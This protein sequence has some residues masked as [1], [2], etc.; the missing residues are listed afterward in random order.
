[1]KDFELV[2]F[3][4]LVLP[5]DVLPQAVGEQIWRQYSDKILVEFPSVKTNHC[6]RLVAQGWV[7][8]IPLTA[9]FALHIRPKVNLQNLFRMWEYAYNLRDLHFLSGLTGVGTLEEFYE[10]LAAVLAQQV[11]DRARKGIHRH[12]VPQ[13]AVLPY[14]RGKMK[15]DWKRPFAVN[16]ATEYH[17]H[18]ADIPDNQLLAYTLHHIAHSHR[19]RPEVQSV[20]RRAYHAVMGAT[21][22]QPMTAADCIGRFYT[23]L[24]QDYQPLHALCRFFLEHS[25]PH[26]AQ[27][28]HAMLP[29]LL[30][31]GR[32]YEL[33]VAAW[34]KAH[35]PA[36]W[37]VKA[38]DTFHLGQHNEM[39][40]SIDLV[41]YDADH[42]AQF[43]LDTKYKTAEKVDPADFY[44]VVTYAKARNSKTAVLIHPVPIPLDIPFNDLR[45]RSLAFA[46]DGNLDQ[47]G[48]RFLGELLR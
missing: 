9:D 26:H 46:L 1:M 21:T 12:Y 4:P 7:G 40:F 22:L 45:V 41:I 48:H 25:A 27:G 15:P 20:V 33:F 43:V 18:T 39:R 19:C 23:R 6:W 37:H 10:Q 29:F 24:N 34:L 2:E 32:L 47:A 30:N 28:D 11:L 5:A 44:Q 42:Q 16:F 8:H 31:M 36:P 14:V 3:T 38:Q 17:Q 35:L 13:T